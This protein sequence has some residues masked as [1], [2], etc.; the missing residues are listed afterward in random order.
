MT[1]ESEKHDKNYVTTPIIA[2]YENRSL[3][4]TGSSGFLGKVI[5][6]KLLRCVPKIKNLYLLIRPQNG[7]DP[8]TRLEKMLESKVSRKL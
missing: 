4:I 3:L 5:V 2:F 7:V 6:E 1:S 8:Q